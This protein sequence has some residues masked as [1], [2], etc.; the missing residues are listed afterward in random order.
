MGG[1][2]ADEEYDYLYKVVLIGDSRVG[3]TNLLARFAKNE[4]SLH[5]K[6]TIGVEFATRVIH[7]DGK[8]LKCQIWDTAGQ[9]RYRAIT[10][11]YYR[12]C[13][14]A[15]VVYDIT[16]KETF[17]NL[18]RWLNELHD[19]M[20]HDN[21][22][23]VML[24]GNKADLA[25]LRVIPKDEA[26]AFAQKENAFYMETSALDTLNVETAFRKLVT[27]VYI[28]KDKNKHC[29]DMDIASIP[30]RQS[31]KGDHESFEDSYSD[32]D[33]SSIRSYARLEK[34]VIS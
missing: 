33:P 17:Q 21:P 25:Y 11:A 2:V 26:K 15:L 10:S 7:F 6:S 19:H 32:T 31:V 16:Q 34:E 30:K 9:D 8:T 27:Q 14:G 12:G 13:V 20:D 22:V 23:V 4:F 18:D 3:K 29:E 5:S 28:T 1:Y 24:I